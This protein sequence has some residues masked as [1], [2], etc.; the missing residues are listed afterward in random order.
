VLRKSDDLAD[1]HARDAHVGLGGELRRL[2]EVDVHAVALR[3]QWRRAAER[4]PQEQEQPEAGQREDRH[5]RELRRGR[6]LLDHQPLASFGQTG[7]C[8]I[9][10]AISGAS[11]GRPVSVEHDV[12]SPPRQ[13][14]PCASSIERIESALWKNHA[15]QKR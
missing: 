14:T 10:I 9:S 13:A 2:G 5:H 8:G 11:D 1:R 7:S 3:R 12:I 6:G 4:L 15:V